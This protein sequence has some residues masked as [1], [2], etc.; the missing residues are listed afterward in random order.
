MK[1]VNNPYTCPSHFKDSHTLH[2]KNSS[3]SNT[4]SQLEKANFHKVFELF[5]KKIMLTMVDTWAPAEIFVGGRGG[6][7]KKVP[8][9]DQKRPPHRESGFNI[10][11]KYFIM[12]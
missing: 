4:N 5:S 8:H 10:Y 2:I 9:K 11:K 3:K 12:T 6:K 7:P 1:K